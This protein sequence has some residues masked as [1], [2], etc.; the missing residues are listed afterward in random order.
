MSFEAEQRDL[1]FEAIKKV[2][3]DRR[4]PGWILDVLSKAAMDAKNLARKIPDSL[5][6]DK[7]SST[8]SL[9]VGSLARNIDKSDKCVYKILDLSTEVQGIRLFNVQIVEGN[10][11]NPAGMLIHNV[12]ETKL[13]PV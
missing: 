7:V 6:D 4:T 10:T 1:L 5:D 8:K 3:T 2:A 12:P 13:I 9:E 11:K